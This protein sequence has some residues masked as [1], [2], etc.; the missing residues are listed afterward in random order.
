M[1]GK[2]NTWAFLWTGTV[3]LV[4]NLENEYRAGRALW[5]MR[6]L[7]KWS[8]KCNIHV[9]ARCEGCQPW[10]CEQCKKSS[11][12]MRGV[13][14]KRHGYQGTDMMQYR[15]RSTDDAA[16]MTKYRGTG[17]AVVQS[18]RVGCPARP[19]VYSF[20][21]RDGRKKRAH[22]RYC[23]G[24]AGGLS[25]LKMCRMDEEVNNGNV[26]LQHE[27]CD[28]SLLHITALDADKA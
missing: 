28:A 17:I 16:Q 11:L 7:R 23:P 1:T 2:E 5:K 22:H 6:E 26:A 18:R 10:R 13:K 20:H 27:R 8:G 25:S 14:I 15:W 12:D 3:G 21:M 24:K 9:Q 4:V 19:C